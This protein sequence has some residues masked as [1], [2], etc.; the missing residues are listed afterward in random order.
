MNKCIHYTHTNT[1]ALIS[2]PNL[3]LSSRNMA[4]G[5]LSLLL[6]S[7]LDRFEAVISDKWVILRSTLSEKY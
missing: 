7:G 4:G 2:I 5:C 3:K 6:L 1:Y